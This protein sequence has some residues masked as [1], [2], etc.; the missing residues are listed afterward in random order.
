LPHSPS[1]SI[2]IGNS[3]TNK[4][5]IVIN[6]VKSP[7]ASTCTRAASPVEGPAAARVAVEAGKQVQTAYMQSKRLSRFSLPSLLAGGL[8]LSLAAG[9][10][11]AETEA[12]G[13][14][15]D[16]ASNIEGW[17]VEEDAD[18]PKN[19]WTWFGMGYESRISGT[20]GSAAAGSGSGVGGA[21]GGAGAPAAI[22]KQRGAGRR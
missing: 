14:E 11:W 8:L 5:N 18:D 17:I 15:P 12:A 6:T 9:N 1:I 7:A 22:M 20:G 19:N 10:A 13:A 4:P 16:P 2:N 21:A 3:R